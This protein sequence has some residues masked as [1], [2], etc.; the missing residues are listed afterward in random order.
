[1][2]QSCTNT[3]LSHVFIMNLFEFILELEYWD[4]S[5]FL[6][7]QFKTINKNLTVNQKIM[8]I[9]IWISETHFK[10]YVSLC[11]IDLY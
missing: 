6:N 7:T 2:L 4:M 3:V 11:K 9:F 1:M 8:D 10:K 5:P